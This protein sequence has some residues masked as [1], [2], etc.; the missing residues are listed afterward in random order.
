MMMVWPDVILWYDEKDFYLFN[1]N[2]CATE[3]LSRYKRV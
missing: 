2:I 1:K 3:R